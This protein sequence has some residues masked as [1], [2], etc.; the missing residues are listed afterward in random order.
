VIDTVNFYDWE[1]KCFSGLSAKEC[2]FGYRD[3]IFKRDLKDKVFITSVVFK[4][5][6]KAQLNTS[7]GA[8]RDELQKMGVEKP[9]L[10]A[11][12]TAVMNIRRSK[13]PDPAV[14]GNAG[15]FFKN[16][17]IPEK[18]FQDL[19]NAYPFITSY[20]GEQGMVKIPAGWLIEQCGWKGYR[21]GYAGVHALQALVLVNYGNASGRDILNLSEQIMISIKERFGILLE[22][23][24]QVWGQD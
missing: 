2:L 6:K 7:Y 3:S 12:A 24:V 20:A 17:V 15:S 23:E 22:R 19:K 9:D 8:I 21:H 1:K 5:H 13:L 16:P 14:I 10:A 11:V 4:L 18:Q